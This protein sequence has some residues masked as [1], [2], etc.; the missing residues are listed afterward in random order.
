VTITELSPTAG[1]EEAVQ[2]RAPSAVP[3]AGEIASARLPA[4]VDEADHRPESAIS[5][6][7]RE[8]DVARDDR[9]GHRIATR[10]RGVFW[11]TEVLIVWLFSQPAGTIRKTTSSAP[12][13][14]SRNH[15]S[16]WRFASSRR[17][18]H[19]LPRRKPVGEHRDEQAARRGTPA[20]RRVDALDRLV[21]RHHPHDQGAEQ[22]SLDAPDPTGRHAQPTDESGDDG[23]EL[24][25]TASFW[26]TRPICAT[27]RNPA[28]PESTP[29]TT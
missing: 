18:R 5:E 26:L 12:V 29:A 14:S 2:E 20:E 3:E 13:M 10:A 24:H 4:S 25:P 22:R 6:P 1:D 21:V 11:I 28:T 23:L 15:V 19:C 8:V 27:L 9:E 17:R 7:G 16:T